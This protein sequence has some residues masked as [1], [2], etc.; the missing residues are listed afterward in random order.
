MNST[1]FGSEK[2][3]REFKKK[4]ESFLDRSSNITNH[5]IVL[6]HGFEGIGKTTLLKKLK[7]IV[8]NSQGQP[9]KD[10]FDILELDWGNQEKQ[11]LI[12]SLIHI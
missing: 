10:S 2:E 3:I 7:D 1:F 5:S 12:L 8:E 4:L 9:F 6:I 11:D